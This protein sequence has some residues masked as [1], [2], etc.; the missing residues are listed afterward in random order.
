MMGFENKLFKIVR[1]FFICFIEPLYHIFFKLIIFF[2][3][4]FASI[5]QKTCGISVCLVGCKRWWEN[6]FD[7]VSTSFV[8]VKYLWFVDFQASYT[9]FLFLKT[10]LFH[11]SYIF[12]EVKIY[13]SSYIVLCFW[14]IYNGQKRRII[15]TSIE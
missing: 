9:F 1:N 10:Q 3:F 14:Y 4:Y 12:L 13:A 11:I 8:F 6:S 7:F 2:L 5:D 15:I